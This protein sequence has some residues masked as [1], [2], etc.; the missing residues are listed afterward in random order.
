MRTGIDK[1]YKLLY[2]FV[3]LDAYCITLWAYNGTL[4]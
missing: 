1:V 3:D 4:S 2:K